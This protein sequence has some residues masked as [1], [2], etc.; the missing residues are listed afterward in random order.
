MRREDFVTRKGLPL[1]GAHVSVD[2]VDDD[3][4]VDGDDTDSH[5]S[6]LSGRQ[7]PAGPLRSCFRGADPG[8][9]VEPGV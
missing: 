5:V 3:V 7:L 6:A 2:A 8:Q 4:S 1:F 9:N